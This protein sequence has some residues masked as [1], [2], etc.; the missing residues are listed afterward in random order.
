KLSRPSLF[1]PCSKALPP[2]PAA[3][4]HCE[5]PTATPAALPAAPDR[6]SL[7]RC[8]PVPESRKPPGA[9][10]AVLRHGGNPALP[11]PSISDHDR[12]AASPSVPGPMRDGPR[13]RTH[14]PTQLAR[15]TE[16]PSPGSQF[17]P[18]DSDTPC[19]S[20]RIRAE[21]SSP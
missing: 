18:S 4:L 8:E 10:D 1:A 17:C 7:C 15:T 19:P 13:Q 21:L 12:V 6:T 2:P 14:P 11:V 5:A 16:W 20:N 9:V 3:H